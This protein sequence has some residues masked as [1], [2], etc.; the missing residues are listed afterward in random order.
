MAVVSILSLV[1]TISYS[2]FSQIC[3]EICYLQPDLVSLGFEEGPVLQDVWVDLVRLPWGTQSIGLV[4]LGGHEDYKGQCTGGRQQWP[5]SY[6]GVW[7]H[8]SENCTCHCCN[9]SHS[10]PRTGFLTWVMI[11]QMNK[12]RF[13]NHTWPYSKPRWSGLIENSKSL[14]W[15]FFHPCDLEWSSRSLKL[16]NPTVQQWLKSSQVS[17]KF[18]HKYL[19]TCQQ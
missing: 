4:S 9:A 15:D 10:V 16:E 7:W 5:S 14:V 17:T 19:S 11:K 1:D 13:I 18:F 6:P 2:Q 3:V 8:Y 12:M